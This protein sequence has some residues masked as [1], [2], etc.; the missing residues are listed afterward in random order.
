MKRWKCVKCKKYKAIDRSK[1]K[2]NDLVFFL[3]NKKGVSG[4]KTMK[5]GNIVAI[6]L[7][8][9]TLNCSGEFY[10]CELSSLYPFRAPA[11][12]VYDIFGVCLCGS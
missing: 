3:K 9:V 4:E 6:S 11:K 1:I 5:K 12:I 8:E 2:T 7:K 10:Q